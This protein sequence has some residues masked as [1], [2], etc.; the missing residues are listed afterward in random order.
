MLKG[1]PSFTIANRNNGG[2]EKG[3]KAGR[4]CGVIKACGGRRGA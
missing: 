3:V 4:N 2:Y 1:P